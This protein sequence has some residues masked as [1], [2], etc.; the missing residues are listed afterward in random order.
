MAALVA[1]QV[2]WAVNLSGGF[3]HATKLKV[4]ASAS[5]QTLL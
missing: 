2:G 5:T 4:E 3:H 1:E